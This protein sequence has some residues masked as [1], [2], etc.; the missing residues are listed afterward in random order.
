MLL[1]GLDADYT[2]LD[3]L[4]DILLTNIYQ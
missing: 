4:F 1:N 3:S 2:N